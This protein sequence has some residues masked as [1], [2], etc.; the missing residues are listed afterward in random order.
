M[1]LFLD[2][3]N[4]SVSCAQASH[5]IDSPLRP[6]GSYLFSTFPKKLQKWLLGG[7]KTQ[8]EVIVSSVVPKKTLIVKQIV[9]KISGGQIWVAGENLPVPIKHKYKNLSK[10]GMDRRVCVYGALRLYKPPFLLLDYGTALTADYVDARGVFQGGMII[11]GPELAYQALLQRA[12]LLPKKTRLPSKRL[13]FLGRSPSECLQTGILQGY[14][15]MAEGLSE[16]FRTRYG[17]SLQVIC[18]GGFA[19]RLAVESKCFDAVDPLLCLRSLRSVFEDQV[20]L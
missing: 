16:R 12:A 14:S 5:S 19:E 8:K 6:L 3:G 11:P 4:T 18:T 1:L 7:G 15:A 2:I 13:P 20:G 9:S 17:K 10:L